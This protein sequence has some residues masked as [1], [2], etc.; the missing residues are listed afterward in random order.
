MP[1]MPRLMSGLMLVGLA[2]QPVGSAAKPRL[3]GASGY[4]RLAARTKREA[5]AVLNAILRDDRIEPK[6]CRFTTE[7]LNDPVETWD[8]QKYLGSR[9][10]AGLV[11]PD[12][13]TRPSDVIDPNGSMRG[14]FCAE[15]HTDA[16][17]RQM[18]DDY[19]SGAR[20]GEP[21]IYDGRRLGSYRLRLD[22]T[23]MTMPVFNTAFT[24]AVVHAWHTSR[25]T[26]KAS[27]KMDEERS[28]LYDAFGVYKRSVRSGTSYTYVYRKRG[29]KWMRVMARQDANFH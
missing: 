11:A 28:K 6:P 2:L 14:S 5:H 16:L 25:Q 3:E 10:N 19:R 1:S 15:N 8:A 22:R 13:G 21:D 24:A 20:Q 7:W 9:L 23:E 17:W 4:E 29:G 26:W 27:E 18:L 12:I